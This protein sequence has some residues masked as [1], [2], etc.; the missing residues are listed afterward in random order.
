[1]PPNAT[2]ENKMSR[3]NDIRITSSKMCSIYRAVFVK[4]SQGKEVNV[5]GFVIPNG[6]VSD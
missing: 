4:F 1:M 2:I 6:I 5:L 3:H